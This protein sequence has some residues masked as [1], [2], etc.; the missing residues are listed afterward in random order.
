MNELVIDPATPAGFGDFSIEYKY[1]NSLYEIS[2]ESRTKGT[3]TTEAITVDDRLVKG[4]RVL[5]VDD[6]EKHRIVV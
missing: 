4:N 3:L 2:V 1:G 6:G 5:L